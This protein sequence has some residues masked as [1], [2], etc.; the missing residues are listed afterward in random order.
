MS[1]PISLKMEKTLQRLTYSCIRQVKPRLS[2]DSLLSDKWVKD[3]IVAV[4]NT[5][6]RETYISR[7]TMDQFYQEIQYPAIKSVDTVIIGGLTFHLDDKKWYVEIP[8]TVADIGWA[9]IKFVGDW[10]YTRSYNRLTFDAFRL[11]DYDRYTSNDP[12]YTY[13][14]N[15]LKLRNLDGIENITMIAIFED[16]RNIDGFDDK[17]SIFP[18]PDVLIPKLE[19][20]VTKNILEKMAVPVDV[21]NDRIDNTQNV[22]VPAERELKRQE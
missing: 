5:L 14:E 16:P 7:A 18:L 6:I 10:D 17:T 4:R 20:I 15:K 12:C 19:L 9:D 22:V 2:D 13:V 21:V 3:Q 1:H 11:I 8:A